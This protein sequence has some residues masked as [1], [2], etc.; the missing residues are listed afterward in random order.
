[1]SSHTAVWFVSV[2]FSSLLVTYEVTASITSISK[3]GTILGFSV[4]TRYRED[5][6]CVSQPP[7]FYDSGMIGVRRRNHKWYDDKK[8]RRR[9]RC[10]VVMKRILLVKH[11]LQYLFAKSYLAKLELT[12]S[13]W[14]EAFEI[15]HFNLFNLYS[16]LFVF[17]FIYTKLI[18]Q[19]CD[20]QK[21]VFWEDSNS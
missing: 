2:M 10:D 4:K 1:M 7:G 6:G 12:N 5:C 16:M 9:D 14:K 15:D 20:Y 13:I 18:L 21:N 8:P 3:S 19:K 11:H 17:H